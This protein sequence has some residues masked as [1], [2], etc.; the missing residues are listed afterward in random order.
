MSSTTIEIIALYVGIFVLGISVSAGI[1][2][3]VSSQ[4]AASYRK[5]CDTPVTTWD[6]VWLDLR[7]DECQCDG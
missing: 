7:I 5:F 6:A 2:W 1:K 4:E 3:F